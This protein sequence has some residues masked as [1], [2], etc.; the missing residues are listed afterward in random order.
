[1]AVFR[2]PRP[3]A[4]SSYFHLK[5]HPPPDRR[6][7]VSVDEYVK[8]HLPYMC[9]WI[10]VRFIVFQ[11]MIKNDMATAFWY[12]EAL[13]DPLAW[14]HKWLAFVGLRLPTPVVEMAKNA[15]LVGNFSFIS[16]YPGDQ[17]PGGKKV[18]PDR[19][20]KDELKPETVEGMD[21]VLRLWLP[22]ALLARYG[23]SAT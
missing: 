1:M 18:T 10:A 2:D 7:K 12:E 13:A 3:M 11:G 14:H 17:H 20:Y 15:A 23:V 9:Q 8:A 21:D 5:I 19:S 6:P 22:P 16:K 4:V